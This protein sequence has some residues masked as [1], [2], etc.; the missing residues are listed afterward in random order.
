MPAH[1]VHARAAP[2]KETPRRLKQAPAERAAPL[3]FVNHVC[4]HD[5]HACSSGC[6]YF[7]GKLITLLAD[8][9]IRVE[10]KEEVRQLS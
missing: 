8:E 4:H 2:P 6:P 9:H 3:L 10:A 7:C 5:L 1:G